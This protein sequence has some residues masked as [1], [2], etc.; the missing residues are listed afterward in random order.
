MWKHTNMA[1]NNKTHNTKIRNKT[2]KK[3]SICKQTMQPDFSGWS[4][5]HNAEPINNGRCC[6]MCNDM[7]VTPRRI[8]EYMKRRDNGKRV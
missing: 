6:G 5:G 8:S 4:D 1:F 7:V 2:M 3:C